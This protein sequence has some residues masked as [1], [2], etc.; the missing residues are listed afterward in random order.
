MERN[1][2]RRK[3]TDRIHAVIAGL[4]ALIASA[5]TASAAAANASAAAPVATAKQAPAMWR[6]YDEDSEVFLFGTFHILPMG[7]NWRTDYYRDALASTAI[8]VVETDTESEPAQAELQRLVLKYGI[9]P[10]GVTLSDRLGKKRAK[11]FIALAAELGVPVAALEAQRPWLALVSISTFAL[12]K[13]GYAADYGVD[14]AVL[15]QARREGDKIAYLESLEEQISALA[16][17]DEDDLIDNFDATIEQFDDFEGFTEQML[18]SWRTGDV[19]M[20][21]EFILS[22]LRD[23]APGAYRSLIVARNE[24]WLISIAAMLAGEDDYF[25]AVGAGHLVG[26]DSVIAL[27]QNAGYTVERVQ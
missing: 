16:T 20:M 13:A 8:T 24:K 2:S 7:V 14:K 27:L 10:P 3:P 25:V 5:L 26:P 15:E 12:Q 6:V 21:D 1:V 23:D 11:Q 22:E 19:A 18:T 4:A 9:N 17:L